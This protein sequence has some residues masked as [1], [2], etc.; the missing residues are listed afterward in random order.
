MKYPV[1]FHLSYDEFT[2]TVK[3][4]YT[5]CSFIDGEGYKGIT[6]EM[7]GKIKSGELVITEYHDAPLG[8]VIYVSPASKLQ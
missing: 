5:C 3:N 2:K 4:I 6:D 1:K 8:E 7:R